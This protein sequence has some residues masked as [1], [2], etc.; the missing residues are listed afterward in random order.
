VPSGVALI[1]VDRE[2]ENMIGVA[3]GANMSLGPADV[4]RVPD[5]LFATAKVFLAS[6]ETPLAT[7]TRGLRRA[8]QCGL[9]TIL[10][11]APAML[12]ILADDLLPQVD[13]LTPN[14]VEAT[15]LAGVEITIDD[16]IDIERAIAAARVLKQR[17]CSAVIVTLGASGVVVV[18]EEAT[19]I[20]AFPVTAID[21]T[22]AGDAFSGA[23]SVALAEGRSLI[24]GARWASRAAALAVSRAGAQPSL[25]TRDEI[26]RFS[27]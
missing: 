3:S 2:A 12:E 6:L 14:E 22:A 17:G 1:L 13:V 18:E 7:V 24:D 11:P 27:T 21:A 25:A 26:D 15:I 8:K 10:N 20:A 4:D 19:H 9:R 5:E 16:Q 23:L